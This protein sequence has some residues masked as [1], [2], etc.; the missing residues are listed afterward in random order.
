MKLL[1]LAFCKSLVT[2]V[3]AVSVALGGVGGSRSLIVVVL[4][5]TEARMGSN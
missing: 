5:V 1:D 2:F 3:R 4:E